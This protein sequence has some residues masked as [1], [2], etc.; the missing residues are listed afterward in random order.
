MLTY[1][2][3]NLRLRPVSKFPD[4]RHHPHCFHWPHFELKNVNFKSVSDC[5][6]LIIV[7]LLHVHPIIP[8]WEFDFLTLHE[9]RHTY[10]RWHGLNNII[11]HPYVLVVDNKNLKQWN[12]N[13]SSCSISCFLSA[14]CLLPDSHLLCFAQTVDTAN[15]RPHS[16]E[17]IS[18]PWALCETKRL[19]NWQQEQEC[20]TCVADC[21]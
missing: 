18:Q 5:L 7:L 4:N 14:A 17:E 6:W 10:T 8:F 9:N 13:R 15:W 16:L 12:N 11:V 2:T 1:K 19:T 20:V 21:S 3:L